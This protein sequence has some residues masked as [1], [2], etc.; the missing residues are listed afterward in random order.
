MYEKLVHVARGAVRGITKPSDTIPTGFERP[1]RG[2][3]KR[4]VTGR[5]YGKIEGH[6]AE[7]SNMSQGEGSVRMNVP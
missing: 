1:E 4:N 6:D 3:E 2:A 7:E 5:Y